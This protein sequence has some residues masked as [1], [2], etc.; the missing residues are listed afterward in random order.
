MDSVKSFGTQTQRKA[1]T[2]V[3]LLVVIGIIAVLAGLL[4]PAL[5]RSKA[6][7]EGT[8]CANNLKQLN[9]AWSL[10]ADDNGGRLL[11]YPRE[12]VAGDMTDRF[13]ATNV[14]LLTDPHQSTFARYITTAR[15]YKCPGDKSPLVRS[16]SIN[17]RMWRS[18]PAPWL[19][20]GGSHYACFETTHQIQKPAE[21]FVFL[22]ERSDTI[23]DASFCV[24]MSSTGSSDGLGASN[25]SW[26]IDF[27]ASYHN[28]S[29]RL[30]FVDGHV[31]AHRWLEATTVLPLGQ[32]HNVT[33]TSATDRDVKWLQE[34]YTYLK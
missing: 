28:K 12:W 8:Q 7:A 19:D 24:D 29:G 23:N 17:G 21:L 20:G 5:A 31:E 1:F 13:D 18:P 3:E 2:L 6:S 26:M 16:I 30:A 22:D 9:G 15:I 34:H 14:F 4:L 25:P 10:Y 33:H 11:T 27:P 32:A